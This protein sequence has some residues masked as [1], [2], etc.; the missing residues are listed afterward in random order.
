VIIVETSSNATYTWL[1]TW[2]SKSFE[3]V[4]DIFFK[5]KKGKQE[6]LNNKAV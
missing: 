4:V 5:K 3:S 1:C 2:E 6:I